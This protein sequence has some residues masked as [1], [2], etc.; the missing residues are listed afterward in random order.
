MHSPEIQR[1]SEQICNTPNWVDLKG[2][3]CVPETVH[4]VLVRVDPTKDLEYCK[5]AHHPAVTDGLHVDIASGGAKVSGL[6]RPLM[7]SASRE[8]RSQAIKEIKQHLLVK[9]IDKYEVR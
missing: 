8:E 1:L 6:K 3:D 9:L 5:T 2:T 4:H 7:Q